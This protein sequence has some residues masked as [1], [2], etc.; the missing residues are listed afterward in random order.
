MA[1]ENVEEK[2]VE[3]QYCLV[4]DSSASKKRPPYLCGKG[5]KEAIYYIPLSADKKTPVKLQAGKALPGARIKIEKGG[6]W[7]GKGSF[8]SD[9]S[10]SKKTQSGR[11]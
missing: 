11:L 1:N 8:P 5:G 3:T 2:L 6:G 4:E 10:Q 9:L 7:R